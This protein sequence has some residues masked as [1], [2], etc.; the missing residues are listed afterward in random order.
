VKSPTIRAIAA[1]GLAAGLLSIPPGCRNAPAKN[2]ATAE[3]RDTEKV[4][5]IICASPGVTE[6]VFGLDAGRRVVGVSDFSIHPPE[7]RRLP[8]IGGL[9]NPNRERITM[10]R[11]NLIITQGKH[12]S[13]T[14]FCR[15]RNIPLLSVP[16]DTLTDLYAAIRT[17]GR[18]LAAEQRAEGLIQELGRELDMIRDRVADRKPRKVFLV[19][20][21]TPG[22]LT[23][24]M[25]AGPGSFLHEILEIAGGENIF[26]DTVG[27]YPQISK[28]ALAVRQPEIILEV[29][30]DGISE[31]NRDLMRS[32]WERLPMLPA[33]RRD[34][35]HYLTDDFLLIPGL[36]LGRIARR[37]AGI[38]HPDAFGER[39]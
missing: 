31:G 10:L 21:H 14:R 23:G 36:R 13:L 12:E 29:F 4:A 20:G 19:L 22:D 7:A 17:I 8:R 33:V 15:E 32:D 39:P 9:Y 26:A 5:R 18:K 16:L 37:F 25:T 35:V 27:L 1:I 34:R 38:F 28:E 30:P 11:P 24:L 3:S 2:G 6:I